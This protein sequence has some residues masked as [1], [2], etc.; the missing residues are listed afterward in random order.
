LEKAEA[1][2]EAAE[3]KTKARLERKNGYILIYL[4]L[5]SK[6]KSFWLGI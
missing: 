1:A 5:R 4:M 3:T 2:A 6:H